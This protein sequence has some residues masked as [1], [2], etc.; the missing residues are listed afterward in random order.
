[1]DQWGSSEVLESQIILSKW[2]TSD[3]RFQMLARLFFEKVQRRV[4]TDCWRRKHNCQCVWVLPVGKSRD[5]H[6][7][8]ETGRRF[9]A[10]RQ[11]ILAERHGESTQ[12]QRLWLEPRNYSVIR[13]RNSLPSFSEPLVLPQMALSSRWKDFSNL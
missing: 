8:C 1:M 12:S 5:A 6:Q 3:I 10:E 9:L 13:G 2:K 4:Q 11:Q 7:E